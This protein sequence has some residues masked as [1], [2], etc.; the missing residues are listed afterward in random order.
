[1][2]TRGPGGKRPETGAFLLAAIGAALL[3][4]HGL[5]GLLFPFRLIGMPELAFVGEWQPTNFSTFQPLELIL[6]GGLYLSLSRGA[7]LPIVRLL[8][9]LGLL[10]LALQHNRHQMLVGFV[11]SLL[12]A[13]PLGK[14]MRPGAMASAAARRGWAVLGLSL[15][16]CLATIRMALPLQ[17]VDA[18]SSPISALSH[19]PPSLAAQ[20][21]FNDYGFGGYLTFAN[22]RP[23][24]DGRAELY[25][26]EFLRLYGAI[27]QPD[28][29]ALEQT[30]Q[31]YGVQWTILAPA[32]PA[33]GLL[34]AL[35]NWCRLYCRPI[36]G[37][38]CPIRDR[39]L[40][41]PVASS[42]A[43]VASHTT[44]PPL[45]PYRRDRGGIGYRWRWCGREDS[46]FHGV[47]P[48]STSSLR[49]YHSA[50]TARG[51]GAG[52]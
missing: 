3:T 48:T 47:S 15:A 5:T 34:D 21:V 2:P 26:G 16:A 19:V 52:V 7:R 17:R 10:H 9:L 13:D 4:P 18:P 8:V 25:Q 41:A 14:S 23:F 42:H 12:I 37:G 30:F 43:T 45:P 33:V 29:T 32:N 44:L 50:T 27:T 49:V 31:R 1:M 51:R 28:K 6:L 36:R 24:I 22:V 39:T 46:N 11:G 38:A 35:G 20:P 40:P